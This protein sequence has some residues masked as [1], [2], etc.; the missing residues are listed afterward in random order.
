MQP[1]AT[2]QLGTGEKETRNINVVG[3]KPTNRC[4][5]GPGGANP[6]T[7]VRHGDGFRWPGALQRLLFACGN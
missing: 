5:E 2:T 3:K 4:Q 7:S 6:G 1:S